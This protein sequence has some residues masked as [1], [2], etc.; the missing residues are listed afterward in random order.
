MWLNFL[1]EVTYVYSETLGI[2]LRIQGN[3]TVF[4]TACVQVSKEQAIYQAEKS[5]SF[6]GSSNFHLNEW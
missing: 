4:V 3:V 6:P 5:Y 2:C 1:L